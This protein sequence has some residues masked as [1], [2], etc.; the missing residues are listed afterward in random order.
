MSGLSSRLSEMKFMRRKAER[1]LRTQLG[2]EEEQ[3]KASIQW[4][5]GS[6]QG[7][8]AG[9]AAGASTRFIYASSAKSALLRVGRRSF[10]RF[11]PLLEKVVSEL[12]LSTR[13]SGARG[14]G[15][16][17]T[18]EQEDEEWANR[19]HTLIEH[20]GLKR[21]HPSASSS[22]EPNGAS[23]ADNPNVHS[24]SSSSSSS[25]PPADMLSQVA[26]VLKKRDAEKR[27]LSSSAQGDTA[28]KEPSAKKKKK[29]KSSNKKD[30]GVEKWDVFNRP[31]GWKKK[32]GGNNNN[33]K[34]EKKKKNSHKE[35]GVREVERF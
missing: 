1:D 35:T 3:R 22:N 2:K 18:T 20:N 19:R 15:E 25:G 30:T 7:G 11:N 9:D 28:V 31:K 4:T 29:K 12:Q 10:G 34:G 33:V 16:A 8:G 21:K 13:A 26:K 23:S 6:A 32:K 24:S 27:K 5:K 14:A 17:L